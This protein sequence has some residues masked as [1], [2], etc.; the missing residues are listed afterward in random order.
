MGAVPPVTRTF[1]SVLE[2][3][4]DAEEMVRRYAEDAGFSEPDQYFIGL[5]FREIFINAMKHGNGFDA[6]KKVVV[7]LACD[8]GRIDIEVIDEGRG[9]GRTR[10][11]RRTWGGGP[12]A[13]W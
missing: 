11:P 1:D 6:N 5:A 8:G 9:F 3:V 2:A 13:A 4:D 7:H 10:V 12:V